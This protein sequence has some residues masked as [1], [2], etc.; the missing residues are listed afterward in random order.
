MVVL[1]CVLALPFVWFGWR[2]VKRILDERRREAEL[3]AEYALTDAELAELRDLTHTLPARIGKA[4]VAYRALT[5]EALAKLEPGD[6]S[7]PVRVDDVVLVKPDQPIGEDR[8]LA[9]AARTIAEATNA[10]EDGT[11][12]KATLAQVRT[13]ARLP[14][15]VIVLAETI[16]EPI[17]VGS[18]YEPGG[19]AGQAYL[20]D[21]ETS[22][23]ACA[24]PVVAQ[25]ST[26]IEYEYSYN[27]NMPLDDDMKAHAAARG[28]LEEDLRHNLEQIVSRELRAVP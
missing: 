10:L 28:K 26:E 11:A 4:S 27:P 24:A 19:V 14:S 1:G 9:V 25:S 21:A 3:E 17:V 7:C 18:A 12:D 15:T 5:R 13:V 6:G 22:R 8:E 16:K 23:I 2:I 20:F